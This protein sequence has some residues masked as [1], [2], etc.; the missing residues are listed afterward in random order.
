MCTWAYDFKYLA[1]WSYQTKCF[2]S[3]WLHTCN[4]KQVS[5]MLLC[6]TLILTRNFVFSRRYNIYCIYVFMCVASV[7]IHCRYIKLCFS[8]N[9]L[10]ATISLNIS[11]I[12]LTWYAAINYLH[13]AMYLVI[14]TISPND[15]TWLSKTVFSNAITLY[16]TVSLWQ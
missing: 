16:R 11:S 2:H 14:H 8:N 13:S 1:N 15:G 6:A 7:C 3:C 10:I 9:A 4:V 12:G 5:D